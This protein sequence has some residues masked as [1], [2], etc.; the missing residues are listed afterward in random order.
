[1]TVSRRACLHRLGTGALALGVAGGPLA[2]AALVGCAAPATPL[3]IAWHPWP[4]YAPLQ[5]AHSLGWWEGLPLQRLATGSASESLAQLRAGRA[6]AAAL[7]LDEVL[8]AHAAGLALRVV[9]VFN[10]SE[11]ADVVLARPERSTPPSWR[12]ARLGH[13]AGAVGEL[14]TATW[15]D[16]AG[17]QPEDVRMVHIP[18]DQ[19]EAAWLRDEVDVLVTFEPVAT[20][21]QQRGAVRIFDSSL[22]PADTAIVD[23]LAVHPQALD[24]H[25]AAGHALLR[26]IFAAQRHLHTLPVD[27][28]Y[29]LSPWLGLPRETVW[30]SFRGLRLTDWADNRAWLVGAQPCLPAAA[31]ALARVMHANALLPSADAPVSL[32]AADW[33]PTDAPTVHL[34][35]GA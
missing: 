23:V 2:A 26:H 11:G 1:M 28:A 8:G 21:L 24:T 17:L 12:G 7:T 9:A 27:S 22:L 32:S 10:L 4:G 34:E 29:R 6:Q 3:T 14:M 35:A 5:L 13:E 16:A 33:L 18:F 15:L 19:H 25:P 30:A 20:R 31:A